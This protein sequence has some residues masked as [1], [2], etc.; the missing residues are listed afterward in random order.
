VVHDHCAPPA[1]IAPFAVLA[2]R[3]STASNA[4]VAAAALLLG[5]AWAIPPEAFTAAM[6]TTPAT[7]WNRIAILQSPRP[8]ELR[9][10][11]MAR[12]SKKEAAVTRMA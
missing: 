1:L 6:R 3:A 8:R 5:M 7:P 12:Q 11:G 4:T 2:G 9:R 10:D